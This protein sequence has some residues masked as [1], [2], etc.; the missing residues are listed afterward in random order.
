MRRKQ[1]EEEGKA[2]T[3]GLFLI[4]TTRLSSSLTVGEPAQTLIVFFVQ[5]CFIHARFFFC[6]RSLQPHR[7]E[8]EAGGHLGH[9]SEN[10]EGDP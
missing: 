4:S 6:F 8:V 7:A 5:K 1:E 9:H 10:S 2:T 3:G